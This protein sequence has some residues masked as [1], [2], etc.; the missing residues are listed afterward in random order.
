MFVIMC[1][2][3][4]FLGILLRSFDALMIQ[5]ALNQPKAIPILHNVKESS[6]SQ[7]YYDIRDRPLVSFSLRNDYSVPILESFI[8]RYGKQLKAA[9]CLVGASTVKSVDQ[10]SSFFFQLK[11]KSYLQKRLP[12]LLTETLTLSVP[13]ISTLAYY[14]AHLFIMFQ[15]SV[16]SDHLM[17]VDPW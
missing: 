12:I 3:F 4:V 10:V 5:D 13:L 11:M 16:L 9:G 17:I 8:S 7:L 15:F 1:E 14:V 2:C 6:L